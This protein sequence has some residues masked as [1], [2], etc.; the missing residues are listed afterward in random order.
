MFKGDGNKNE[1]YLGTRVKTDAVRK[2]KL[3]LWKQVDAARLDDAAND[4]GVIR[5]AKRQDEF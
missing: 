2:G 3:S 5:P 1:A 4:R